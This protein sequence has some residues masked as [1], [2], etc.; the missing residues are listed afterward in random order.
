VNAVNYPPVPLTKAF[1][2]QANM[3]IAGLSGLLTGATDPDQINGAADPLSFDNGFTSTITVGSVSVGGATP[4]TGGTF[5][6]LNAAVGTFDFDP[7]PGFSGSC[8]LT[9]TLTDNGFPAPGATSAA[10][11]ITMTVSGPVI[12]FVNPTVAGPGD[13]RLSNPFKFLSGNPGTNNDADDVDAA[14]QIIFVYSGTATGGISLLAGEK[15]IGQGVTGSFDTF[16][17]TTPPAGTIARPALGGTTPVIQGTVTL[18]GNNNVV[19]GL[20]I[21]P[22]SG[23]RGLVA[24]SSVTGIQVGAGSFPASSS[25][26]SISSTSAAA[27]D[28]SGGGSGDFIFTSV[29]VTGNSTAA[30]GILINN[31]SASTGSFTVKGTGTANSGGTIQNTTGAGISLTQ[32]SNLSFDRMNIQTTGRSGVSGTQVATFTF[33]NGT[34]N[35]SGTLSAPVDDRSNIGFG[36]QST[37]TENNVSG[38]VTIT[39]NTLTNA[40]EH[41]V[42]IQNF[43]GTITNAVITGNTLTSSTSSASSSGSGIRLLGFGSSS[44]VSN[45]TKALIDS[46]TIT[47]FPG[48]AGITAQYGN[49]V[50]GGAAGTWGTPGSLTNRIVISNNNI[51]GQSAANPMNTNA[52]LMTLSGAGQANWLADSNGTAANPITNVGGAEIG[53]SIAG[54]TAVATADVTNNHIQGITSSGAQAIAY[55]ASFQIANTEAPQLTG[56]ISGNTVSGQDGVGIQVLATNSN[57]SISVSVLNNTV[58]APNCG[59]CNRYGIRADSG[60]SNTT[61]VNPNVCLNISGNTSAG[62]GLNTGIGI[63]RRTNATFNIKNLPV[64][65]GQSPQLQ[66]YINS[67]NPNGGGTTLGS[68]TSGFASCTTAP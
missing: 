33:T 15:L 38:V 41:G 46:N 24:S 66:T 31:F 17:G 52:I 2:V 54:A 21:Q 62:S 29:S 4:C 10:T 44:G 50:S 45:I 28:L 32:T 18:G 9:Y 42:D 20:T 23:S 37:V 59:G 11:T 64:G 47:N 61:G 49:A 19:R 26:V 30:N 8:T 65:D 63:T 14:N 25:D 58:S 48:G 68:A 12:W 16:F 22:P 40:F 55:S 67:L 57:A 7:P 36:F 51:K 60:S 56:T 13:G 53:V 39:G 35:N 5:S 1:T 27:I 3:K 6:N 34:I 43:A